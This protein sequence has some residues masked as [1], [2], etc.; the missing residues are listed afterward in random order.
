M[1]KNIIF[2]LLSFSLLSQNISLNHSFLNENLRYNI[3]NKNTQ[4]DYSFTIRPIDIK[5]LINSNKVLN[6]MNYSINLLSN[7]KKSF[8]LNLLPI[9]YFISYDDHHPYNRNN[10]SMIPNR[11]YQ[12]LFSAG[13]FIKIGPLSIKLQPEHH[14]SEN[15]KFDGFWEGHYPA[16]WAQ[17]YNLWN[18]ID[19]PE[20]FGS[21]RHNRSL[22]GQSNIKLNF[23][24]LSLG[25]SNENLWWGPSIRNS[26][27][28]SN[29]AQGFKH[30]T[31][32]TNK[33]VNIGIGKIEWQL[34]SGRLESSGF[35]PPRTDYTFAGTKLF[36]PKINQQGRTDDWRYMQGL[37]FTYSPKW[38]KNFHI[39]FIRWVQMYSAL[40]EGKYWWMEGEPTYFPVFQNLFR[41]NDKY[42]NY[43]A[44]TNQ[45]AGIFFKW[46]WEDSKA[47]IYGEFYH[48]DSKQNLRDLFLDSDHSR[49]ATI[50][51]QKIFKIKN[52]DFLFSWEWTQMEQ[53][54]GRLIRNAGS[55]Y[56]HRW[57]YDGYT[58]RGEVLGSG[59]GPGSN[60]HYL[61]LNKIENNSKYGIAI[62]IVDNDNDFNYL[63][64]ESAKDYRRYWKD[65]NFH[66][67]FDKIF[68]KIFVS[69]R[70]IYSR[71]FN[72]QWELDD[73]ATPYYHP[74]RDTNNFHATLKLSYILGGAD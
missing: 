23:K 66:L 1:I 36:V 35:N 68:K 62:E 73:F 48:N 60:S 44:Q 72:Y 4:S 57:V 20:R 15:K 47:E 56:Q 43:E 52:S 14:F 9:D 39:G 51:L 40:V 74:G 69:S 6:V 16:I 45:A 13:L 59:I 71:N 28:L 8:E 38:I 64:F 58:N 34:I 42:E 7:K 3:L 21:I 5:H 12:H 2:L 24:S 65:L 70:L 27:M 55:W 41:S 53:T 49:A 19:M 29:H 67:K 30:I 17:R 33:P 50:G 11:G 22:I 37:I 25:I 46:Q 26:I 61:S 10:G 32:N 54:A 31:F 63:A 18:H